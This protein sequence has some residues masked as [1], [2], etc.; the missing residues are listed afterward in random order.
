MSFR[1][2]KKGD[3]V[4]RLLA[5]VIPMDL[6]VVDV[7]GDR[8]ICGGGWEFDRDTGIEIDDFISVH[9]SHLVES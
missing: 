1:H 2:I 7:V 4:R 9:V 8:I 3:T 6:L 5:G